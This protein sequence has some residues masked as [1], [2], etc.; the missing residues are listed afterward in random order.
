LPLGEVSTF[1]HDEVLPGDDLEVRGPIGRWFV[2]RGDT[3]ALLIGGGSGVVPLMAML[4]LARRR[5]MSRQVRLVV[6]V[7]TPGDLY[8][9]DELPGP[10]TAVVYTR[11]APSS[12]LRPPGRIIEDDIAP[13]VVHEQVAYIC[14]SSSFAEAATELALSA[15]VPQ[16][17]IRI[18]RFGPTG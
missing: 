2:W 18:E 15:G 14:G 7:R 10:E 9:S 3:P 13:F 5:G 6:S 12:Y 17:R 16:E 1:L 8:Y 4:R 11:E